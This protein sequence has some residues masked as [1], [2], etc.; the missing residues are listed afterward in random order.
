[1]EITDEVFKRIALELDQGEPITSQ[2]PCFAAFAVVAAL[3]L[4]LR[5]PGLLPPVRPVVEKA[6][7]DLQA[8]IAERSP[9][10]AVALE[11]GWNEALDD[12][13]VR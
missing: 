4:A 6:A 11:D 9:L 12:R 3:Q 13:E 5:H 2:I 7:L 8:A 1:M 10:A